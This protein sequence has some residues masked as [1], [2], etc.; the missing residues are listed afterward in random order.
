LD[1]LL[2]LAVAAEF[3]GAGDRT[4]N[5]CGDLENRLGNGMPVVSVVVPDV[6]E[7]CAAAERMEFTVIGLSEYDTREIRMKLGPE[8]TELAAMDKKGGRQQDW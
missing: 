8:G 1:A 3:E 5:D 6:D 2:V 4:R 7:G